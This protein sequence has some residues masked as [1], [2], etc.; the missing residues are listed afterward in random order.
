MKLT[1]LINEE[2]YT[3]IDPKGNPAGTGTKLQANQRQ[4][5]LG[6]SKKGYFVVPAKK[7]L[8]ARRTLE[9][10]KFDFKNTKLQ[11]MMSDLYF[12]GVE[13]SVNEGAS[14]EEKRI[15]MLAVRKIAK[16]RNVPIDQ[17]VGDVMRAA[18]ELERDIQKGKVK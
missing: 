4:K 13:E 5:K 18:Q 11:D 14:S 12:E 9:K 1:D 16:Y 15:V 10:Y 3:L 17:S 8:K 7:A 6:G 2:K